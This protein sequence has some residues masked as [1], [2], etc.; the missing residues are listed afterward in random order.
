MRSSPFIVLSVA[1]HVAL[2]AAL[3]WALNKEISPAKPED[4][5]IAVSQTENDGAT[6]T[7]TVPTPAKGIV[8]GLKKPKA[9]VAALLKRHPQPEVQ[10]KTS[11]PVSPVSESSDPQTEVNDA[12]AVTEPSNTAS[13]SPSS[14]DAT[15]TE[16]QTT[17]ASAQET[18]TDDP[19]PV[20]YSEAGDGKEEAVPY[21]GLKQA[22]P[23]KPPAYPIKARRERRQGQ[24]ELVYRVTHEGLVTDISVDKSSG[25]QDLDKAALEAVSKYHFEP[26]Q[27]G[28][29]RHP[30]AFTL[31]GPEEELPSKLRTGRG[32][33]QADVE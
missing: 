19:A 20:G 25:H 16:D 4:A 5:E 33:P 13:E 6:E 15:T 30:I 29:A 18:H 31:K 11:A 3:I 17:E 2:V 27:E 26:G 9:S 24:L 7:G 12:A 10:A 23:N 21:S 8:S 28:W 22:G 1:A 14:E 32:S